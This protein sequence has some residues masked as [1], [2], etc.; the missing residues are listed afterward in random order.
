MMTN[1]AF[2]ASGGL[3]RGA[4]CKVKVKE[5]DGAGY[6]AIELLFI[7]SLKTGPYIR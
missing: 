1:T 6:L 3:V 4:W 7:F 5:V 2:P